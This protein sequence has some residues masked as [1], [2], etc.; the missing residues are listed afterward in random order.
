MSSPQT[1]HKACSFARDVKQATTVKE[2]P[3]AVPLSGLRQG[4]GEAMGD[5]SPEL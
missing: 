1:T 5:I 2:E 3:A 4:K